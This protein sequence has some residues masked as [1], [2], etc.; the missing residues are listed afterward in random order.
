MPGKGVRTS[1]RQK[2]RGSASDVRED[3]E[4]CQPS[5][6]ETESHHRQEVEYEPHYPNLKWNQLKAKLAP[7]EAEQNKIN[8]LLAKVETL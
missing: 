8:I 4:E 6:V 5:S 3:E 7:T 2:I 1:S